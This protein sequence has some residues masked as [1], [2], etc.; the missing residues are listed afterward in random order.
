MAQR[1]VVINFNG[2]TQITDVI[3]EPFI[4]QNNTGQDI[5]VLFSDTVPTEDNIDDGWLVT[6]KL[7]FGRPDDLYA[8]VGS[9]CYVRVRDGGSDAKRKLIITVTSI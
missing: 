4:A 1:G 7:E 3:D 6:A 5:A 9:H 2:W 8:P